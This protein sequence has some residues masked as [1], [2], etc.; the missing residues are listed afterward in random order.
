MTLKVLSVAGF[1][2]SGGA[3]ITSDA[4]I[5][6]K[7]KILGLS[8][9]TAMTAQNPDNIYR[10]E[11]VS[12]GF[13]LEEL[14]AVFD[15]FAVDAVK[16]GLIFNE[17]Q[18]FILSKFLN[19]YEPKLVVVD[20]VYIS[21]S[22]KLLAAKSNYPDFFMP[23]F[24]NAT[25]IT[26]NTLEAELISGINIKG[27]NGMKKAARI[28]RKKIPEIKNIIIKGS[29]ISE[30]TNENK[31]FNI[32]LNSKNEFFIHESKRLKIDKKIHGTGCAF[33]ACLTA[34]L[35]KNM[36]I[37][38]ALLETDKFVAKIIAGLKKIPDNTA[39][40]RIYITGNI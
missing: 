25:V 30:G 2:G 8:A 4:K 24:K 37:E 29:H 23:L 9:I 35:V 16:T 20:P 18:S 5:F 11:P 13:F 34:M 6:S 27:L 32:I 28:I 22:D 40:K 14:K 19:Q 1:D 31:I 3:G 33:S 15:Y 36:K 17:G 21:T 12:E 26:P 39:E 7:F 10:I 38:D